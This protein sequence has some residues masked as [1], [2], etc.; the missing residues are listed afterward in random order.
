MPHKLS[1]HRAGKEL[2]KPE[3]RQ[4]EA[5]LRRNGY[6][7]DA[8]KRAVREGR[9]ANR[10]RPEQLAGIEAALWCLAAPVLPIAA[11]RYCQRCFPLPSDGAGGQSTQT[12]FDH[13]ML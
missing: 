11:L 5:G 7:I 6:N 13:S 4:E 9:T 8:F 10:T 2:P 12:R 3:R 1:P